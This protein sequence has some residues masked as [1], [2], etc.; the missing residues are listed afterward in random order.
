[1]NTN[2]TSGRSSR[3]TNSLK[4]ALI[5]GSMFAA[6]MGTGLIARQDAA[7]LA[8]AVTIDE[9]AVATVGDTTTAALPPSGPSLGELPAIPRAATANIQILTR[10]RS[11]R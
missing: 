6:I 8:T 11:S 2:R 4:A 10:S 5:A 3:S 7:Q 1:M 9:A